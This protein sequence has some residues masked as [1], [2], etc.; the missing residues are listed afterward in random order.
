MV[1]NVVRIGWILTFFWILIIVFLIIKNPVPSTLNEM[2]DFIA[3]VSSPLAFLWVVVGY[4][5]SQQALVMQAEELSQNTRALTAQVE[6]MKK[7]TELQEDQ[8][9][10][11]KMQYEKTALNEQKKLQP[12]FHVKI[13]G[14]ADKK[15]YLII[16]LSLCCENGFA[17]NI[18][19]E[20]V[21]GGS[22]SDFYSFI[23]S[24]DKH[25]LKIN[26]I[27]GS[28]NELN[29]NSFDIIYCDVNHQFMKQRFKFFKNNTDENKFLFDKFIYSHNKI[30]NL[31]L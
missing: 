5:Q 23:K 28:I 31:V 9:S 6:E 24:Q 18:A 19:I 12:F 30:N 1:K 22:I 20:H 29:N 4:Y 8:L 27:V 17:R 14:V 13:E 15:D 11:M 10:E 2:G 25:I 21:E 3:G 16:E 26:I 7:T